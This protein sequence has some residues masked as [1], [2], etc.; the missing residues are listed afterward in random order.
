MVLDDANG[1]PGLADRQV[2]LLPCEWVIDLGREYGLDCHLP[3][4][5]GD[6]QLVADLVP[7]H[8][9]EQ[10]VDL[11]RVGVVAQDEHLNLQVVDVRDAVE[12]RLDV[13]DLG[14]DEVLHVQVG[15]DRAVERLL[16]VVEHLELYRCREQVPQDDCIG[17]AGE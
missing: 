8:S 9:A 1:Q 3:I 5:V 2:G 17:V 15:A 13:V 6:L 4:L 10:V 7:A 12:D 14:L 16:A 11:G